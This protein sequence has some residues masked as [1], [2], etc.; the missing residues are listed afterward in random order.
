MFTVVAAT[1]PQVLVIRVDGELDIDAA[2]SSRSD[3][4]RTLHRALD[5]TARTTSP[6]LVVVDLRG[7]TMLSAAGL[8]VLSD[9]AADLNSRGITTTVAVQR[10]SLARRLLY[11]AG[12]DQHLIVLDAPLSTSS[13]AEDCR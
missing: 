6:S 5:D 13:D 8:H 12:L 9:F 3:L 7:L 4:D 11:L 2:D 10:D 1:D